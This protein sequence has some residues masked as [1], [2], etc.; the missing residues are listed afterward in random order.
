MIVSNIYRSPQ[1][2]LADIDRDFSRAD[3]EFH[4][5]DHSGAS[6]EG[7]VF[8]NNAD[9]DENTDTTAASGYAGSFHVFG[10]GGC[11]GDEGH[12]DVLPRRTYDPR[13]AHPLTPAVKVVIATEAVNA[14]LGADS[15]T[16]TVTVVPVVTSLTEKCGADNVLSF[17]SVRI[18]TYR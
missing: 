17:E 3:I 9:A 14:A 1:I 2:S 7:R 15:E 5:L 13:A 4:E 10:H 12:C 18:V 8:L 6:F 16:I 11:F